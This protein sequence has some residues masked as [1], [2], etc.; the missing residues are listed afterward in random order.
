MWP[1]RW[2][3]I[4]STRQST[5]TIPTSDLGPNGLDR[6]HQISF[7]GTFDLPG[8]IRFGVVSHIYSPLADTLSLPAP[9]LG[10]I[11]SADV[12]GD[13]SGDGS[14]VYLGLG[15]PVPGSKIGSFGR[16]IKS[17]DLASFI[18]NYNA[19]QAGQAT[20]AGQVLIQ[21]GLFTLPQLQALGGI[22]PALAAPPSG[23]VGLGWLRTFDFKLSYPR[24]IG[25]NFTIEPGISVFNAFNNAN[26]DLP[27][28]TLTG[29]LQPASAPCNPNDPV[30]VFNCVGSVNSTTAATRTTRVT[31]GSGVFDL[32]A[33][34]VFEFGLKLSF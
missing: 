12:T 24:K 14:G 31:P 27:G 15:D 29:V 7:G 33:P 1:R 28:N 5:T 23:Q 30:G 32:G 11:F 26:F 18:A 21:N 6:T 9:S 4:S 22:L 17:G 20:P 10:G 2:I 19:T 8:Y 13:G 25:E 16:D 34:R 3:P